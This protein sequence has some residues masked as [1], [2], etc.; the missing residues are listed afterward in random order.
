MVTHNRAVKS[1]AED[2]TADHNEA[3]K[4]EEDHKKK[5]V[6]RRD[7]GSE[8][9][10]E[11]THGKNYS[12]KVK[13]LTLGHSVREL[14]EVKVNSRTCKDSD[15]KYRAVLKVGEVKTVLHINDKIGHKRL[16][17]NTEDSNRKKCCIEGQ[18]LLDNR[19]TEAVD[20]IAE[21]TGL[22]DSG[23]ILKEEDTNHTA[24]ADK[25]TEADE[26]RGISTAK[27]CKN[28][29]AACY[30]KETYERENGKH[31]LNV[32][33]VRGLCIIC[34]PS[35]EGRIVGGRAK[36][37][38]HTVANYKESEAE[39]DNLGGR[40]GEHRADNVGSK[41][42]EE[43]YCNTPNDIADRDKAT[44]VTQLVRECTCNQGDE[45]CRNTAELYHKG[46]GIKGTVGKIKAAEGLVN[47]GSEEHILYRPGDLSDNTEHQ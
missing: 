45:R 28:T 47:E 21:A 43:G 12:R 34:Y 37:G 46:Y 27:A 19:G 10:S 35:I 1:G 38:H 3:S 41:T 22:L 44:S 31:A 39:R 6:L 25:H 26:H 7:E 30:D 42:A 15:S 32:A 24:D 40:L 20:D 13:K 33:S 8:I 17:G 4:T 36:E 11:K 23:C 2:V 18:M 29:K 14:T 9:H 16:D 5:L